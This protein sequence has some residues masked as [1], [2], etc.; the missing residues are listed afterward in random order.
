MPVHSNSVTL[1]LSIHAL[2]IIALAMGCIFRLAGIDMSIRN[3][4]LSDHHALPKDFCALSGSS[5]L[6]L[7]PLAYLDDRK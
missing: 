1:S 7:A 2:L 4:N 5:I 3:Q 6:S